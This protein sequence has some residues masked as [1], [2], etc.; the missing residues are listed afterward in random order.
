MDVN[1]MHNNTGT[2]HFK[3]AS[4]SLLLVAILILGIIGKTISQETEFAPHVTA[5]CKSGT[6]NIKIIFTAAY[7]GI[8]H[9]RDFRTLSCMAFGNGSAAVTLSLNL[10]AKQGN[11]DY[12]GILVSNVHGGERTEER[13]V[14]LAVRVHKTLEL[15]DDKFYVITCGKTGLA[16]DDNSPVTLKFFDN[17]RRIQ[18]TV[19]GRKYHVKAE[20]THPN[21]TQG[22]RVRNCFA[23]NKKN[24]TIA[25]IDDRGCPIMNSGTYIMTRFQTTT[26]GTTAIATLNSMFRFPEGSEVHFQCDVLQCNG[27]CPEENSSIC[28]EDI[29][30]TKSTRTLGQAEQGILLAATTVFVL[31]PIDAKALGPLCD[32]AGIRPHWLLW[33]TIALAVL[34]LIMLLMNIFLCTAMSCSC[35]RTEIIE[36]E[37]SIIEEY[38][39]YRSW[40]GSQYG[41]RYSLH[42]RDGGHN[43]GYTSGGSTIHSNRSLPIDSDH[44]AIVHSRPG[45]RHSGL[46]G[47]RSRGPPSNM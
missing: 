31:D 9:A 35:A 2:T 25:L 20:I 22:I 39:P 23:F 38:D 33:L 21:G 46:H 36:K 10:L 16:R 32:D 12:C 40:H 11:S 7:N 47:H 17:D 37:P 14:Q 24:N 27:L 5:T 30:N 44:Y 18:E 42:G 6:M 43:K 34:F 45:S 3:M 15:A 28:T 1:K 41:S 26:N 8:V 13:S 29:A 4:C 19:Y